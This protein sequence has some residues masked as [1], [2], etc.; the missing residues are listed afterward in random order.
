MQMLG[1]LAAEPRRRRCGQRRPVAAHVDEREARVAVPAGDA[2]HPARNRFVQSART[3]S[4]HDRDPERSSFT[5][6]VSMAGTIRVATRKVFCER[7]TIGPDS[8]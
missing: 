3:R 2:E 8:V 5:S 4:G 1:P 7:S 6:R